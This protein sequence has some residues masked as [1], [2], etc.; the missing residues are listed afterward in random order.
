MKS[1]ASQRSSRLAGWAW[2]EAVFEHRAV[3]GEG[4]RVIGHDQAAPLAGNVGSAGRLDAEVTL[5]EKSKRG[6]TARGIL[7]V[8]AELVDLFRAVAHRDA[9]PLA[10]VVVAREQ[11]ARSIC[12]PAVV[13]PG[14]LEDRWAH[15]SRSA[16]RARRAPG[17]PFESG[18]LLLASLDHLIELKLEVAD[19]LLDL[20]DGGRG[21][22]GDVVDAP[23][24]GR[25]SGDGLARRIERGVFGARGR[26]RTGITLSRV[27]FAAPSARPRAAAAERGARR[28]PPVE[29]FAASSGD[30]LV[31]LRVAMVS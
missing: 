9:A 2:R 7:R 5:V 11:L 18:A 4:A 13:A 3:V 15:W 28:R 25:R 1:S 31:G 23:V 10:Q 29:G 20:F 22:G 8:E 19:L 21:G 6:C 17:V 14:A 12:D 16:M 30:F 26:L 24:V 27:D